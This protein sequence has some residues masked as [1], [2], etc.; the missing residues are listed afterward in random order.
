MFKSEISAKNFLGYQFGA[1]ADDCQP[2]EN[3]ELQIDR[4][5]GNCSKTHYTVTPLQNI[6]ACI[7]HNSSGPQFNIPFDNPLAGAAKIVT[8][9][10]DDD[11]PVI[12]CGFHLDDTTGINEVSPDGKTLYHY[13]IKL[14]DSS[15]FRFNEA[16]F[17]YNVV[18]SYC[19]LVDH[20]LTSKCYEGKS[21]LTLHLP[22]HA[23][24]CTA[25]TTV[26]LMFESMLL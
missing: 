21:V 5:G 18:V 15:E 3:L 6:A 10:L 12:Q 9:Q 17:F 20:I 14:A 11:P 26:K 2:P 1:V 13:T 7:G 25:R 4:T 22:P 16:R 24:L 23:F 19:V 8:V